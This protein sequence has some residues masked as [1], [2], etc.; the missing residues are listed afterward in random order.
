M[1][2][3]FHKGQDQDQIFDLV[4][5]SKG[6]FTYQ[7]VYHMPVY[8]RIFY[9]KKLE[10]LFEEQKKGHEKAMKDARSK[11]RSRSPKTRR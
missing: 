1:Q 7:D 2:L 3:V 4:Y 8:L 10:R 5:H 11:S 6:G 9:I